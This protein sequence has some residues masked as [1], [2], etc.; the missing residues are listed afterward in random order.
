METEQKKTDQ[1]RTNEGNNEIEKATRHSAPPRQICTCIRSVAMFA[2]RWFLPQ[3]TML[4]TRNPLRRILPFLFIHLQSLFGPLFFT[5][6]ERQTRLVRHRKYAQVVS[7]IC[8]LSEKVGPSGGE[9]T[10]GRG[11]VR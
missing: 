7:C 5:R 6:H 10:D 2:G 9:G 3:I 4:S 1:W 11:G 8:A